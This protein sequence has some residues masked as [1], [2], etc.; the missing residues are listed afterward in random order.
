M[1]LQQ[2]VSRKQ[3]YTDFSYTDVKLLLGKNILLSL[4][5]IFCNLMETVKKKTTGDK[6][7]VKFTTIT[8][9]NKSKQQIISTETNEHSEETM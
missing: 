7:E 3:K 6:I 9:I 8:V 1:I 5:E 2:Q 4:W